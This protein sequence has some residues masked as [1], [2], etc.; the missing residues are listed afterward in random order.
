MANI[1]LI[2]WK[3]LTDLLSLFYSLNT[4]VGTFQQKL[5]GTFFKKVPFNSLLKKETHQSSIAMWESPSFFFFFPAFSTT[6]PFSL[7]GYLPETLDLHIKPSHIMSCPILSL[8]IVSQSS[9]PSQIVS[10]LD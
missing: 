9:K 10:C 7:P 4:N 2:P 1:A 6:S 5:F 8:L 3:L